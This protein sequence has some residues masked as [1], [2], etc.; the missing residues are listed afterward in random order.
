MNTKTTRV[1]VKH[2]VYFESCFLSFFFFFY[3]WSMSLTFLLS[4]ALVEGNKF[5]LLV[6]NFLNLNVIHYVLR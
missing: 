6:L 4:S 3:F 5:T 2:K 1:Y